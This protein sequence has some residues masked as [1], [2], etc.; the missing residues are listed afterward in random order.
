[1]VMAM[2]TGHDGSLATCHANGALDALRRLEVMV[3]QGGDLPLPPSVISSTR[4]STSSSTS[5][6]GRVAAATWSRWSRCVEPACEA[7]AR[8]RP[9]AVPRVWSA[10]RLRARR[11]SEARARSRP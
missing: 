9:L 3:L 8:V 4:R 6:G 7:G 10:R 11:R 1:M 5:L 2:S